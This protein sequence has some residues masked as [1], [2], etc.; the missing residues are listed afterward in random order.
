VEFTVA[1]AVLPLV[2]VP[3][4]VVLLNVVV[5]PIHIAM[6]PVIGAMVVV[7]FTV[8]ILVT[9][10]EKQLFDIVYEIVAVPSVTP[11]TVPVAST[12]A[13]DTLLLLQVPPVTESSILVPADTS[14]GPVSPAVGALT[15]MVF[16]AVAVPQLLATV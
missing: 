8:T 14:D 16:I 4:V 9:V 15:V 10:K 5:L 13:T 11:L 2:H 6:A 7:V 12:V 1:T 3:P